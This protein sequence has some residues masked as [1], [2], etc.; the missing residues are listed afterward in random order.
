MSPL[1]KR[2]FP[3]RYQDNVNLDFR[4]SRRPSAYLLRR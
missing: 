2:H 3:N 1:Q 4:K